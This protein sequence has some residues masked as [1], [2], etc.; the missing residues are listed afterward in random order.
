MGRERRS[1]DRRRPVMRALVALTVVLAGSVVAIGESTKPANASIVVPPGYTVTELARQPTFWSPYRMEIA[2]DG[3]IFVLEQ[4]GRVRVVKNDVMLGKPFYTFS[5]NVGTD[6]GLISMAL[7]PNFPAT[8]YIYFYCSTTTGSDVVNRITRLTA[9]G[10]VAG[11]GQ[12]GEH[13]AERHARPG[14]LPLR[15]RHVDRHRRQALPRD[16]RSAGG[17]QRVVADEPVGKDPP[18]QHRRDDPDRQPV[19]RPD[20]RRGARDLGLGTPQSVA[21]H[22]AREHGRRVLERCGL[23]HVGGARQ[24]RAGREL[25][26]ADLRRDRR[27]ARRATPTPFGSTTTTPGARTAAP[28]WVATSTNPKSRSCRPSSTEPSSLPTTATG[29][30][31]ASTST[32]A[33]PCAI[34]STDSSARSM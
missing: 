7:S 20:D 25:R 33:T 18:H 17:P 12:R 31:R 29:G 32:T 10:D 3:R 26:L 23:E 22:G 13:L 9:N 2:P 6:R 15:R 27:T 16:R 14:V 4:A 30:S 21:E 34:C 28:S 24:G 11:P 5:V 19:L 8:P 1:G